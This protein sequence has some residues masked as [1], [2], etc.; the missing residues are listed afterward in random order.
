MT[1]TE[2]ARRRRWSRWLL[3]GLVVVVAAGLGFWAGRTAVTPSTDPAGPTAAAVLVSVS[4][5]TVG[6]GFAFNVT[7]SQPQHSLAVNALR[8]VVTWVGLSGTKK[9][10]AVLYRVAG[11]PVRVVA[12]KVPFY[13]SLAKGAKGSDVR[14]LRAALVELG[15]LKLGGSA[16]DDATVSAVKAWQGELGMKRTGVVRLGELVAAASL[17]GTIVLEKK[18]LQLGDVLGGGERVV[19]APTGEPEF[20]MELSS[21]Q[22][23]LVPSTATI[24]IRHGQDAWKAVIAKSEQT[25]SGTTRLIL[26]ADDGGP[27]CADKCTSVS[28]STESYLP[29]DVQVV[30]PA[31][32][33]AVPVAAVTTHADGSTTVV[34][35]AGDGTKTD[36][37][38]TVRGSQDGV[39]VVDGLT[40][41]ERV[42]VLGPSASDPPT[43]SAPAASPSPSR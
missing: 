35:V 20:T 26:A 29:A 40:V 33:P 2:G 7:V 24:T 10:G 28:G 37:E 13:R 3:G 8:G 22:A 21:D 4:Q 30:A 9:P 41:G 18:A 11:V 15:Y 42:Q 25:E 43:D 5:Q 34:V 16:F 12:G 38:V 32:G 19:F 6:R 17:P 1:L 39:A 31:S 27:V 23:K 36:R 14:Q